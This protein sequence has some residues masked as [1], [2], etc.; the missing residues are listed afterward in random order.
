MF[1]YMYADFLSRRAGGWEIVGYDFP[2]WGLVSDKL[3][4]PPGKTLETGQ[5]HPMEVDKLLETAVREGADWIDVGAY[6]MRLAYFAD[7]R[8][9]FVKLFGPPRH[10]DI[11][12]D[13]LAIGIR[14]GNILDGVDADHTPLPL[15]YY[16]RLVFETGLKPVFVGQIDENWYGRAVHD[17]FDEARFINNGDLGDFQT[18]RN[19]RHVAV[20]VNALSW[21]ASYLSE[22]AENIHLAVAGFMNPDQRPDIDVL[23]VGDRRYHFRFFPVCK[24]YGS[25]H[26]KSVLAS[27]VRWA[28]PAPAEFTYLGYG[29]AKEQPPVL[30]SRDVGTMISDAVQNRKP[31]CFLRLGDGEGALLN[32]AGDTAN[33]EDMGYLKTHFGPQATIDTMLAARSGLERSLLAADLI[34]LRDEIW[35]SDERCHG[36]KESDPDFVSL[37]RENFPLRLSEKHIIG[38]YG[39]RRVFRLFQWARTS[40]PAHVPACSQWVNYDLAQTGFFQKLIAGLP[41][42]NLIHCSPTLAARIA[43]ATNVAVRSFAIPDKA[44][45]QSQWVGHGIPAKPHYPDAFHR[46]CDALVGQCAGEVFLVGAGLAGK[47]YLRIIKENHGIALDLGALLDAWEGRATRPQIYA[48][49]TVNGWQKGDPVPE[50][51]VF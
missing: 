24:Y 36:M 47:E 18:V 25:E 40:Y 51:F 22:R 5:Y 19:A 39:C 50:A 3:A 46:V 2:E 8:E 44:V 17:Q 15:I 23:P 45:Q 10:V 32:F 35:L 1:R 14:T 49:K 12:D 16:R 48:H 20:G 26:Q 43:T 34:G 4:L 38:D 27:A 13:E 11:A 28:T 31:F 9:H 30:S 7:R 37:F 33:D 42:I 6:A 41:R 21:L 29:K